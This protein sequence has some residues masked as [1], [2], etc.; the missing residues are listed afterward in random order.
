MGHSAITSKQARIHNVFCGLYWFDRVSTGS[1]ELFNDWFIYFHSVNCAQD[2][3]IRKDVN[4]NNGEKNPICAVDATA[5]APLR[6]FLRDISNL[7]WENCVFFAL[8][9]LLFEMPAFLLQC[10][11]SHAHHNNCA[12]L[13]TVFLN[14]RLQNGDNFYQ[15]ELSSRLLLQ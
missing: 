14:K 7:F 3:W 11:F 15:M 9:L 12:N 10:V 1:T 6:N 4:N 5:T 2:H 13:N 8:N